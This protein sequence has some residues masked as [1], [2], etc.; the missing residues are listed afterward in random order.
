MSSLYIPDSVKLKSRIN[1]RKCIKKKF[2]NS[3]E[4]VL[5]RQVGVCI[6]SF[7]KTVYL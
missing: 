1:I 3:I 7:I 6:Y 5:Y 2:L 4:I